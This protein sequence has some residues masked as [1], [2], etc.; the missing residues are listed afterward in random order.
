M[1]SNEN[2]PFLRSSVPWDSGCAGDSLIPQVQQSLM[3]NLETEV[4]QGQ[5]WAEI[6]QAC[7][8][9]RKC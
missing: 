4:E 2:G 8:D 3:D 5:K 6:H 7:W 1:N 9:R